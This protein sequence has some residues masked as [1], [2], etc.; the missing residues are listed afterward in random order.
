[1]QQQGLR[2]VVGKKYNH[3]ANHG[4]VPDG[5]ANILKRDFETETINQKWCTD[6]TYIHV[7][8]EGWT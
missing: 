8:K 5:K 7:Q 2:S 6:I 1:M 3:H 4:S